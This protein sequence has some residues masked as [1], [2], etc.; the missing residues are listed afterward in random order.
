MSQGGKDAM[1][2]ADDQL[3][4]A[5]SSSFVPAATSIDGIR[6]M[7][8]SDRAALLE[9]TALWAAIPADERDGKKGKAAK[10]HLESAQSSVQLLMT[11]LSLVVPATTE[12]SSASASSSA[13]RERSE[14]AKGKNLHGKLPALPIWR[15]DQN[16]RPFLQSLELKLEGN[17]I[18]ESRYC[19]ALLAATADDIGVAAYVSARIVK[20]NL[21][22][23]EGKA[24]FMRTYS[25]ATAED[26]V[27]LDLAQCAQ[28]PGEAIATF[29]CRYEELLTT[30][31]VVDGDKQAIV[32][33]HLA[34]LPAVRLKLNEVENS[35]DSVAFS[36]EQ[37]QPVK[38]LKSTMRMLMRL[39]PT[40]AN[41]STQGVEKLVPWCFK[42]KDRHAKD[43]CPKRVSSTAGAVS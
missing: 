23:S 31:E 8:E 10:A 5:S 7:L 24:L 39:A 18:P 38:T 37:A 33:L 41:L 15:N 6:S 42:C 14:A 19:R 27:R 29:L 25:T 4:A 34:L 9:A 2:E 16:P 28:K 12:S 43:R 40:L 36:Q 17:S 1:Q 22:W 21:S 11:S 20:A 30:A 32:A 26:R 35:A 3:P 13:S